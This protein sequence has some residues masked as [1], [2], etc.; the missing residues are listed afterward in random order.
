[1]NDMTPFAVRLTP[2]RAKTMLEEAGAK[3]VCVVGRGK[4][5]FAF[6][7]TGR[8]H[9]AWVIRGDAWVRNFANDVMRELRAH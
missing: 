5:F 7:E 6:F 8:R 1:M 3:N 9:Q 2:D 4:M